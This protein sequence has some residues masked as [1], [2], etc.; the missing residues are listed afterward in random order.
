MSYHSGLGYSEELPLNPFENIKSKYKEF[1]DKDTTGACS[2]LQE[3]NC[4]LG[5]IILFVLFLVIFLVFMR[6]G[7]ETHTYMLT[8]SIIHK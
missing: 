5:K 6:A 3:N 2:K 8:F 7:N 4:R 1:S